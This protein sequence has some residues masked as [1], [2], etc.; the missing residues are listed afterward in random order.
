M[1]QCCK[2][3]RNIVPKNTELVYVIFVYICDLLF[4]GFAVIGCTEF[5]RKHECTI[6]NFIQTSV[7]FGSKDDIFA[8]YNEIAALNVFTSDFGYSY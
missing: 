1:K 4:G 3:E 5:K 6:P 2:N 8:R 7:A